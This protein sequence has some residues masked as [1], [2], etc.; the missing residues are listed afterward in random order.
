MNIKFRAKMRKIKACQN[1]Y[2]SSARAIKM[3]N[4]MSFCVSFGY[5]RLNAPTSPINFTGACKSY[6]KSAALG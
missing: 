6:L 3:L 5:Q 4:V 2:F 1:S